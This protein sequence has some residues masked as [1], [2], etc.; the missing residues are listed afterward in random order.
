MGGRTF[1]ENE[2]LALAHDRAGERDDLSLPNG[3][4]TAAARDLGVECDPVFIRKLLKREEPS[5][6]QSIV[7][8]CVIVLAEHVQVVPKGAAEQF[9][10]YP[11]ER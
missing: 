3:K 11:E 2:E 5:G 4:I 1:I 9:R 8:R 6:A 10:L 7:E